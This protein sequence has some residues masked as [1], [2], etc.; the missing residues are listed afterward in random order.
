MEKR[1]RKITIALVASL[2]LGATNI[3]AQRHARDSRQYFDYGDPLMS[4]VLQS[5]DGKSVEVRVNTASSMFSFLR[6]RDGYYALRDITITVN[7]E[8]NGQPV[9]TRNR[10]DTIFVKSFEQS[11]AKNDWHAASEQIAIPAMAAD[12]KYSVRIEVRDNV[13]HLMM[14]PIT[15]PL[16]NT[17]IANCADSTGIGIGD[18]MLFDT[19]E[20]T[21][22]ASSALGN[23]YMFGQDMM[24][25]VQIR[26]ADTIK[27]QATV[28]IRVR[29][30]TNA[31]NVSDTG[32]R[33]SITLTANDLKKD[34]AF[35]LKRES[36]KLLYSLEPKTGV[37]TAMFTV[38]GKNFEQGTYEIAMHVKAGAVE[39]T[40]TNT[41]NVMWQGMPLSLEDPV[42][43][44]EPLVHIMSK[45]EAKNIASGS[46]QEQMRKL[47]QYWKTKDPTPGTAYNERMAAF[48]QRVDY[49]DFNYANT[50]LLNGVMTDRGKIYLLYGAPTNVKRTF[51]PGEMPVE[52]WTYSNNVNRIFHFEDPTAHGEYRL[53][54]VDNVAAIEQPAAK[55]N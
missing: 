29:Q 7:E 28:E 24:G 52:T 46:K 26:L 41:V 9:V 11:T 34:A 6:A 55:T 47:Y 43:A 19:Q 23:S 30:V 17:Q 35:A 22:G 10:L 32:L 14:R 42:D 15:T 53:V 1:M 33:A 18:A 13:D 40:V 49:A 54:G 39:K 20:G 31:I 37:T 27:E 36:N 2:V 16:R 51:L 50:R 38:P 48:Y 3:Y 21:V 44:I 45:D 25:A 12:K 5:P 8:G 4:S